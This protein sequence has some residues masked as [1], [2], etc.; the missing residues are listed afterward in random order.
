M[1]ASK[2]PQGIEE[3][4]DRKIKSPDISSKGKTKLPMTKEKLKKLFDK[5]HEQ[6]KGL[7]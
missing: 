5:L 7:K 3:K 6:N 2:T 1:L 4:W